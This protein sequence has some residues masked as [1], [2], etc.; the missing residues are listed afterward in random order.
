M[1]MK[2]LTEKFLLHLKS[3]RNFSG[4]TIKAYQTDLREFLSYAS[5]SGVVSADKMDRMMV[6]G[7][8]ASL[9]EKKISR[10]TLLRKLSAVRSFFSYLVSIGEM[11]TDPFELVTMPKKEKRLPRFM[12]EGEVSKLS[13]MNVPEEVGAKE[14]GYLHAPRDYAIFE[15]LYSSG[16]RRSEASGLNIGDLDFYSGFVRVFGKGAKER[17]V[18]VGD[19]ALRALR[20]YLDTRP[21]PL[22]PG[23]PLFL[24]HRNERLTDAGIALIIKKMARRARFSRTLNAH[25]VRHSFATH[26]LDHGCDLKSVQEMLGHRN[27]GTT[28]IYTHVSLERLKAVYDKTHPRSGGK[29]EKS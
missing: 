22:S 1:A 23:L 5:S 4:H 16:L 13:E 11:R 2:L 19:K 15:L 27:L 6:R 8:M 25:A 17:L 20:S 9:G 12:T 7:F 28:Q 14:P 3:Q 26:L 29:K 10:N 18:P 21:R 24:N